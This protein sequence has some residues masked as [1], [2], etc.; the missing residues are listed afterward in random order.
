[1]PSAALI[2]DA[3]PPALHQ[4]KPREKMEMKARAKAK[5]R[6][7]AVC[8]TDDDARTPI[9]KKHHKQS[10]DYLWRTGLAGGLAGSAVC[11]EFAEC[12]HHKTIEY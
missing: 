3:L 2:D 12:A 4:D 10:W 11:F 5:G 6:E 1:M 8:P 7:P 9:A